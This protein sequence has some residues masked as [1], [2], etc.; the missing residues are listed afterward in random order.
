MR[1]AKQLK[2]HGVNR[3][4]VKQ[5]LKREQ[6]YTVH[7]P[8]K[9]RYA[10]N[11]TYVAE[12]VAQ[13]Q[14]DLADMQAIARQ[15]KGE[16]YLLTVIDVFL[17]YAWVAIVKSKDARFFTRAFRYILNAAA[18]RHPNRFQT[19]NGKVFFNATFADLIKCYNIQHFASE[20]VQK[21][22]VGKRFNRTIKTCI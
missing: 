3:Q 20:G 21:A 19:D 7:R 6:A 1:C 17:R 18:K 2:V 10:Q 16:Q 12:I 14:A 9:R 5:F 13:L 8:S 22:A 15:N 11:H 4:V